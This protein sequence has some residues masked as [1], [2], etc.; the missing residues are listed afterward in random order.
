MKNIATKLGKLYA[1]SKGPARTATK[2]MSNNATNMVRGA[3]RTGQILSQ[4][5]K[6]GGASIGD[7]IRR[8]FGKKK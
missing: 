1:K 4:L 8:S 3:K 2:A 7:Y 6:K 5:P